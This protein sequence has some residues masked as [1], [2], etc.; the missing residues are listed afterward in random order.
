MNYKILLF[1][2]VIGFFGISCIDITVSEFMPYIALHSIRTY[3]SYEIKLDCDNPVTLSVLDITVSSSP[4]ILEKSIISTIGKG[5]NSNPF[6]ILLDVEISVIFG[7]ASANCDLVVT[8]NN[9]QFLT[10]LGFII[11]TP[12][13]SCCAIFL[14]CVVTL[15]VMCVFCT[16]AVTWLLSTCCCCFRQKQ[17]MEN[18]ITF[19]VPMP[20]VNPD[21][22]YT[23]I[24]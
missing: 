3:A 6:E 13:I 23:P 14:I 11:A 17:S 8:D 2:L 7:D 18:N 24:V 10:I 15:V 12:I 20:I 19:S 22:S 9:T 5:Q 16:S 1:L 4:V 21:P